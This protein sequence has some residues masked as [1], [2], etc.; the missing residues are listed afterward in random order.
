MFPISLLIVY[1]EI[2]K[3]ALGDGFGFATPTSYSD[4]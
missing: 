3:R 1:V 2:E 4:S